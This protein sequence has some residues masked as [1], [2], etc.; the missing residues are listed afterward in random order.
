MLSLIDNIAFSV[1]CQQ[2]ECKSV[3]FNPV[4]NEA[5]LLFR[6]QQKASDLVCPCCGKKVYIQENKT[7]YMRDFPIF[8]GIKQRIK[9]F[10][11]RYQC[12]ECSRVFT[13]DPGLLRYPG[14]RIT[15]RA[16]ENIRQLLRYHI[17]ISAISKITGIRWNTIAQIHKTYME[18]VLSKRETELSAK[19][20]KPKHLAVDE[21]AVHKGHTY[22]TCV[23]DLD[24]GDI[25][26]VGVGRS[27]TCFDR[28]FREYDLS[29]LS[30]VKAI[31]MDMNASYNQL[32]EKYLPHVAIVYDRYHMQAQFG[33]DVLGS[34]RLE[35]AKEHQTKA[36]TYTEL[37][38]QTADRES[39]RT[40]KN[41]AR[42]ERHT[43]SSIKG[44]RW[45]V[46][47]SERKLSDK[48][49]DSLRKILE[50]HEKLAVCYAMKEEM[51]EL[52]K[53]TNP[54]L[55]REKWINWFEGAKASGIPQLVKFAELKE[56]RLEGLVSHAAFPISTG[57][58]EGFNN[59]IKVAKRTGY[60]YRNDDYF[61]TLIRYLSIP[62][63]SLFHMFC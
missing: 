11:H 22:A 54:I 62:V 53:L 10:L 38:K 29:L 16:A 2:F 14:T 6:S 59:K 26:W 27:K 57:K 63:D 35:E 30:D 3:E 8:F 31:A 39:R 21:F 55:A 50:T 20:Y 51:N 44:S 12:T 15:H 17:P 19:G 40:L 28:F 45:S 33:K 43:Y 41:Q 32:V 34:V 58:L 47:M 25:L 60:G 61:F 24:E 36:Q 18:E 1:S 37:A 52:F 9:V 7:I 5:C 42:L 49:K 4:N 46:L 56:K 13:E 23:M 48:R